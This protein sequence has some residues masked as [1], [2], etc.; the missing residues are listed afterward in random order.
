MGVNYVQL[1]NGEPVVDL[2]GVT[3]N[4]DVL[5]EGYT[6]IDSK[7]NLV[8]GKASTQ[9]GDSAVKEVAIIT[10]DFDVAS[11]TVSNMSHTHQQILD[12]VNSGQFC[13]YKAKTIFGP[14]FGTLAHH[15]FSNNKLWFQLMFYANVGNGMTLYYFSTTVDADNTVSVEPKIVSLLG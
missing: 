14:A 6:A 9:G 5:L 4:E 2:R 12:A 15:E 1:G 8:T 11:M 7:G 10:C 3:V 13:I